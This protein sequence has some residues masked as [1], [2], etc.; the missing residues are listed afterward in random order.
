M[1]VTKNLT[2][3]HH[4]YRVEMTAKRP[5]P[6]YAAVCSCGWRSESLP[7]AGLAGTAFDIHVAEVD[8]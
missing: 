3:L 7:T 5:R 4:G 2:N 8:R 6:L 1:L